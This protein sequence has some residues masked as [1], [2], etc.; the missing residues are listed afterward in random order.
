L[1][2]P[3]GRLIVVGQDDERAPQFVR[4]RGD[5]ERLGGA[6]QSGNGRFSVT[7]YGCG[8]CGAEGRMVENRLEKGAEL[9]HRT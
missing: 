7:G 6:R 4:Q 8:A 1:P 2:K 3:L 5:D 9:G